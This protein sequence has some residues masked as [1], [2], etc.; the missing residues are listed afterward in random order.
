VREEGG[1]HLLLPDPV[2]ACTEGDETEH[3]P[4]R[5]EPALAGA[6]VDERRGPPPPDVHGQPLDGHHVAPG[7]PPDRG[8][9]GDTRRA[10][11]EHRAAAALT[12][13]A[14]AVLHRGAAE[15]LTQHVEQRRGAVRRLDLDAVEPEGGH[16]RRAGGRPVTLS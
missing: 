1:S 7:D 12:L 14:A 5:A 13:G 6:G 3:D 2:P 16:G 15:L 10:V 8:D 4:R 9:A 11:D